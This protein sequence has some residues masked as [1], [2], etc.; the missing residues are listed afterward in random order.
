MADP[1][2]GTADPGGDPEY[3]SQAAY[4]PRGPREGGSPQGPYGDGGPGRWSRDAHPGGQGPAVRGGHPEQREAG[5][6][7]GADGA[8]RGSDAGETAGRVLQGTPGAAFGSGRPDGPRQEYVEAFDDGVFGTSAGSAA[9]RAV[10]APGPRHPGPG[11][12]SGD[13]RP[14]AVGRP[15]TATAR[16]GPQTPPPGGLMPDPGPAPLRGPRDRRPGTP[17]PWNRYEGPGAPARDALTDTGGL[18]RD[19]AVPTRGSGFPRATPP[20]RVP[21]QGE[22]GGTSGDGRGGAKARAFT[23]VLAAAVTTVLAFVVAGQVSGGA[24][25]S[26]GQGDDAAGAERGLSADDSASRSDKG[27]G[28]R[29]EAQGAPLTY[30]QKMAKPLSLDADF[31]GKGDFTA[32]SGTDEGVG[33]DKVMRYRVDVE[34]GLPLESDL[35]AQAVQKTLNDK[36][37]WAHGGE[38]SFER[39]SKGDVDFVITLASSPTTDEWCAKSGL[40]TSEQNVSCD[41]ASTDRVM[42]NAYRW[43]QGSKTFGDKRMLAYRQMLINHEVGHRL[44][45]NHVGCPKDGALAPVM[46]QQTK[47]LESGGDKCRPNPWPYPKG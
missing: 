14:Q 7:W 5:G 2:Y 20:P 3:R 43:A 19:Q 8:G 27:R 23:G 22:P 36:R 41:S 6:G 12:G 39:V 16:G 29:T 33:G 34:K 15:Q 40:D 18:R 38:R 25:Q 9:A 17:G 32:A 35:F 1:D 45:R 13:G 11:A 42:I 24:Q 44:G 10:R 21:E 46:M 30:T 47:S 31:K 26:R 37:S 28:P 4:A